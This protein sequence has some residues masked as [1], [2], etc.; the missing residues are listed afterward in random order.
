MTFIFPGAR[1]QFIQ[2]FPRTLL[3]L[4]EGCVSVLREFQLMVD[5]RLAF[6][7]R[8]RSCCSGGRGSRGQRRIGSLPGTFLTDDILSVLCPERP[9]WTRIDLGMV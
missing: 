8:P 9:H 4:R 3:T 2:G 5:W 1:A 6:P 7:G